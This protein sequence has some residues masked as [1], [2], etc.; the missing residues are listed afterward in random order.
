MTRTLRLALVL[1]VLGI[2]G[3]IDVAATH[4]PAFAC[5][6]SP[7]CSGGPPPRATMKRWQPIRDR[8]GESMIGRSHY[9]DH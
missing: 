2:L 9:E 8:E 7:K 3:G 6:S 1:A 5:T 4:A